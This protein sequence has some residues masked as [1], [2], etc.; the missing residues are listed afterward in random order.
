ML[1]AVVAAL[2][3]QEEGVVVA[4]LP[5]QVVVVAVVVLPFQEE[6]VVVAV[7]L[8]LLRTVH[9][10]LLCCRPRVFHF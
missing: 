9:L 3:F 1:L 5:F 8:R 4:V 2:P 10:V 7:V 6:E